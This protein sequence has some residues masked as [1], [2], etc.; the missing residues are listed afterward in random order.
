M[1]NLRKLIS[2]AWTQKF[3]NASTIELRMDVIDPN[4][5]LACRQDARRK[6]EKRRGAYEFTPSQHAEA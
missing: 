2:G 4:L 1:H 5:T 3:A 6:C